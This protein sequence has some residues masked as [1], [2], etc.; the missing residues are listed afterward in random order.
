[1]KTLKKFALLGLLA[2]LLFSLLSFTNAVAGEGKVVTIKIYESCKA[3]GGIA[4][5]QVVED[6]KSRFIELELH[7]PNNPELNKNAE[8]INNLLDQYY[9]V[10][11]KIASSQSLGNDRGSLTTYILTK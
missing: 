8:T 2:P 1:M 11:Y 7:K 10:G 9:N 6:G 3:C 4:K 5:I